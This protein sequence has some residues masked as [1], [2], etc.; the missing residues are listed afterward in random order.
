MAQ[1]YFSI[2]MATRNRPTDF[3]KAVDSVLAQSFRDIE[4]IVVNDGSE[5]GC[6]A[7]YSAILDTINGVPVQVVSLVRRPN[8]HGQSFAINSGVGKTKAPYVCFLDDDDYWTDPRHL[9]RA[10][11]VISSSPVDLYMANQAA[12]RGANLQSGP[13]WLEDLGP[14]FERLSR[15]PE[16][17]GSFTVSVEDLLKSWSFCHLNTLIVRRTLYEDIGGMDEAIRWECDHDL[18]LRLIDRA[19]VMTFMPVVVS[20]HNIPDP[21]RKSSMTTGLTETE[22]R[23][24]QLAVFRRAQYLARHPMIRA[25]AQKHTAYTLKQIAE[26]LAAAGRYL[27]ASSYAREALRAGTTLK[28]IGYTA[29]LT[30]RALLSVRAGTGQ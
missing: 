29:W 1:A 14:I 17:N 28:W 23:L 6:Q 11:D 4:I 20:G 19:A 30:V 10:A 7:Q 18:Y 2:I 25:Y 16:R 13:I 8:G 21:A 9:E 24:F 12:Y 26:S 3:R 22:R 27:D 5:D 15:S